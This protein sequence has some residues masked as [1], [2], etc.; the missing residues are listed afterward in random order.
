MRRE[1]WS[2]PMIY[3]TLAQFCVIVLHD[4]NIVPPPSCLLSS[5]STMSHKSQLNFES[6]FYLNSCRYSDE[7]GGAKEFFLL[8][9]WHPLLSNTAREQFLSQCL[10]HPDKWDEV[11]VAF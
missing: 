5:L 4:G 7:T 6:G 10:D 2:E 3:G 1:I 8:H 9:M 11:I